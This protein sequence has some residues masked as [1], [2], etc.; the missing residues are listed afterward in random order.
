LSLVVEVLQ[1]TVVVLLVQ[2]VV[3]A[4]VGS[5]LVRCIWL[6]QHTR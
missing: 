3:V 1:Q 4:V 5:I 6:Q 2:V